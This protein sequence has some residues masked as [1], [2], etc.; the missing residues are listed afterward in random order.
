MRKHHALAAIGASPNAVLAVGV[1]AARA[2]A[3]CLRCDD[4]RDAS[5]EHQRLVIRREAHCYASV[6]LVAVHAARFFRDLAAAADFF[7][8]SPLDSTAM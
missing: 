1:P 2:D 6:H 5:L 8:R 3:R 7:T 4:L